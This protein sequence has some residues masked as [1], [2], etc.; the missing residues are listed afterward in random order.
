MSTDTNR[1]ILCCAKKGRSPCFYLV[2]TIYPSTN[3]G[4]SALSGNNTAPPLAKTGLSHHLMPDLSEQ[5]IPGI[6]PGTFYMQT[7]DSNAS[8]ALPS[9]RRSRRPVYKGLVPLC[10]PPPQA[11]P[12]NLTTTPATGSNSRSSPFKPHHHRLPIHTQREMAPVGGGQN[13]VP[14]SGGQELSRQPL[15]SQ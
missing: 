10:F 4:L 6:E 12:F 1:I 5:A 13:S 14:F 2:Q 7:I 15:H 8:H 11:A 3:P 9:I